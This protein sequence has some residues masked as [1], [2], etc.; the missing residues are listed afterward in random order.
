MASLEVIKQECDEQ[1][2]SR[3]KIVR[4][5]AADGAVVGE[6]CKGHGNKHLNDQAK[7]EAK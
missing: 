1:G 3:R 7:L 6:Y 5:F 4:V 2:C